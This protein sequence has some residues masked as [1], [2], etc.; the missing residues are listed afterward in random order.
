[1]SCLNAVLMRLLRSLLGAS[2]TN[3]VL[4]KGCILSGPPGP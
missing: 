4:A 3:A 2:S 1:M